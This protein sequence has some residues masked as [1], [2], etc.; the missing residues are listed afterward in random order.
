MPKTKISQYDSTSAGANLN[1]DIAGINI[2]EGCAPSGINNAIRTLMAQIRDLQ[3]GVSGDS[4][5]VTAGGTG[6]TTALGARTNLSA[7]ASGANSDIT[8][9]TGLTTPLT[10]AQGG[11]GG[12]NA[13]TARSNLGLAIGTDVQAYSANTAFINALQTYTASQRGTV[14]TDNDGSFS[15]AVTNNF[16]CTPTAT[17]ALTFTNITAGQSGYVLLVNTGGYAVTAAAT[18]K[19]NTSFLTT[20]STA[21]TYLLSYFTDGTNVYVTT[22]GAMA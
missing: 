8:S 17:F 13:T 4:I 21:G 20:V 19:V 1:T 6:S 9:I 11:T 10:V 15:M 16:L 18:T 14:T 5:P 12:A 2:D 3:S 7:A 22:G